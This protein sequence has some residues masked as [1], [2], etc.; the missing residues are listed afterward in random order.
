MAIV[1]VYTS[2]GRE[3]NQFNS[4]DYDMKDPSIR[5][6]FAWDVIN[7]LDE[8]TYVEGGGHFIDEVYGDYPNDGGRIDTDSDQ[9][10]GGTGET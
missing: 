3:I 6:R 2:D 9:E 5:A 1:V 4:V 8:A 10:M 7:A